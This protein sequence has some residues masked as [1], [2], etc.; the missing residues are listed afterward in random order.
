MKATMLR[1]T[2]N[3]RNSCGNQESPEPSWAPTAWAMPSAGYVGSSG[4]CPH[5][6]V[7]GRCCSSVNS[8]SERRMMAKLWKCSCGCHKKDT[9]HHTPSVH[10][11]VATSAITTQ[12]YDSTHRLPTAANVTIVM[13]AVQALSHK[14]QQTWHLQVALPPAS[15]SRMGHCLLAL[16]SL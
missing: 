4:T 9:V 6:A 8:I 1:T 2:S 11:H 13:M 15:N 3:G 16:K 7:H 14:Q 12:S 10:A 5:N